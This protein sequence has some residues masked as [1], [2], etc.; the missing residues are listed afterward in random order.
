MAP[1]VCRGHGTSSSLQWLCHGESPWCRDVLSIAPKMSGAP[2]SLSLSSSPETKGEHSVQHHLCPLG[3]QRVPLHPKYLRPEVHASA[4]L[5]DKQE[6]LHRYPNSSEVV[7]SPWRPVHRPT[8]NSNIRISVGLPRARYQGPEHLAQT[9]IT[10][11]A[12]GA[13]R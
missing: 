12:H 6:D 9:A 5:G 4:P 8:H 3:S 13:M 10:T 2:L 11:A 7:G 1:S